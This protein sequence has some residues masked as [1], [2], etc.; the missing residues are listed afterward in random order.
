MGVELLLLSNSSKGLLK[1]SLIHFLLHQQW[2][3]VRNNIF[4]NNS[5]DQKENN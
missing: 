1:Y 4:V 5:R 3:H 2:L